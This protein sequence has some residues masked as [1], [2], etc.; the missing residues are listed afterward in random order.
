M[1]CSGGT[2]CGLALSVVARTKSRMAFFAAPSFHDGSGSVLSGWLLAGTAR[3]KHENTAGT[4]THRQLRR[5]MVNTSPP[6]GLDAPEAN[7]ERPGVR[8]R[9]VST[10]RRPRD[11][12]LWL[13]STNARN[14]ALVTFDSLCVLLVER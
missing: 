4:K 3:N 14:W 9:R 2:Y 1:R 11:C 8:A 5:S 7:V 12:G 13:A 6:A 10:P